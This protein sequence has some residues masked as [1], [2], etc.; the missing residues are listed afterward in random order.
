MT[1]YTP[2]PWKV[3]RN[4]RVYPPAPYLVDHDDKEIDLEANINLIA[5]ALQL[6]AACQFSLVFAQEIARISA[7]HQ[8]MAESVIRHLQAAIRQAEGQPTQEGK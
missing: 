4:A 8:I 5:A 2:G 3:R 1:P 6:L 7:P